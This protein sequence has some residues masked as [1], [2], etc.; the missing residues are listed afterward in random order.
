MASILELFQS[1]LLLNTNV[2]KLTSDVGRLSTLVSDLSDRVIRLEG[3]GELIAEKS[4]SAALQAV[5]L[6][7][8]QLLKEIYELKSRI[9]S[10][11]FSASQNSSSLLK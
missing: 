8:N 9:D 5:Q 10:I 7:N 2:E 4:K 6:T 1:T 3:S 11:E